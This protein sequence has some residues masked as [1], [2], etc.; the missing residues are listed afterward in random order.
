MTA[1]LRW[2]RGLGSLVL[3]ACSA[4]T[5]AGSQ[6]GTAGSGGASTAGVVGTPS[7]AGAAAAGTRAASP[8]GTQDASSS[9]GGRAS[10]G[11]DADA[12]T[13]LVD[14]AI[15]APDAGITNE[16]SRIDCRAEPTFSDDPELAQRFEGDNGVFDDG[17]TAAGDLLKHACEM[18]RDPACPLVIPNPPPCPRVA[19][20]KVLEQAVDCAGQCQAGAC[21]GSCPDFGDVLQVLA[22]EPNAVVFSSPNPAR[23]LRCRLIVEQPEDAFDCS[24][25]KVGQQGFVSSLGLQTKYCTGGAFGNVGVCFVPDCV[26]IG[27]SC[28]YECATEAS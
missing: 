19:T 12:A 13:L 2:A 17:C 25:V 3:V 15:P 24:T 18:I 22:I 16:T 6:Q 26:Q 9:L 8:I 21:E 10:D 27:Q 28:T 23:R 11:N 14:A 7:S 1:A 5:P 20:G 4:P